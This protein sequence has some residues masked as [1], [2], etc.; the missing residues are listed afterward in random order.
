MGAFK[1]FINHDSQ[2][3]ATKNARSLA[4]NRHFHS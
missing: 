4:Y 1:A 3:L 2:Y